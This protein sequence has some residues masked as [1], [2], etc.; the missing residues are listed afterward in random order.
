MEWRTVATP[1]VVDGLLVPVGIAAAV[2]A[3]HAPGAAAAITFS[4]LGLTVLLGRER[5]SRIAHQHRSLHDPLTGAA[6][7]ALFGELLEAAIRREGRTGAGGALLIIGLDDFKAINDTQGHQRGDQVLCAVAERLRRC[8]RHA[9]TVARIGGDKSRAGLA[10][11]R[12]PH[13]SP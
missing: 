7:R 3:P 5:K 13:R 12:R 11:N 9:D 2:E 6:N 8:L 10:A 1:V 4:V